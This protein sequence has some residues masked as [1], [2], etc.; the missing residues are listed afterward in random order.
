MGPPVPWQS[1]CSRWSPTDVGLAGSRVAAL[2]ATGGEVLH[3]GAEGRGGQDDQNG[4]QQPAAT[5]GQGAAHLDEHPADR[6][7][8]TGGHTQLSVERAASC[9]EKTRRPAPVAVMATAGTVVHRCGWRGHPG[10]KDTHHR[11]AE[12]EGQ[13]HGTGDHALGG[14]GEDDQVEDQGRHRSGDQRAGDDAR[15]RNGLGHG[16]CLDVV[17]ALGGV[18]VDAHG[19]LALAVGWCCTAVERGLDAGCSP[20]SDGRDVR[21]RSVLGEVELGELTARGDA[22]LGEDVAQVEGDRPG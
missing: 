7:S 22:G 15:D 19:G 3:G 9:G 17:A 13:K 21:R 10:R 8:I 4:R 20:R 2:D 11:P 18:G 16:A 5:T 6:A 14:A 12:P 1:M